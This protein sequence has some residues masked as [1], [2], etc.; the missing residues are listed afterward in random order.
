MLELQLCQL[1]GKRRHGGTWCPCLERGGERNGMPFSPH[2]W[3]LVRAL[4]FSI[5]Q[6]PQ[7]LVQQ[8]LGPAGTQGHL[9]T[10]LP[11]LGCSSPTGL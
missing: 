8:V 7:P 11:L 9:L 4:A 10:A 1:C 6:D 2:P 3:F 5:G